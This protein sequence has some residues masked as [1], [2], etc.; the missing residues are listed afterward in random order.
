MTAAAV[1]Q[2]SQAKRVKPCAQLL[3]VDIEHHDDE[4][5]QDHHRTDIDQHEHDGEELRFDQQ[6]DG[7]RG[8]EAD[9]QRQRR[10]HRVA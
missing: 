4:Q 2:P 5:E 3:E 6:P 1:S 9:D 10:I 7:R 8:D